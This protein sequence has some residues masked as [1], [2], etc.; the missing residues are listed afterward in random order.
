MPL[1]NVIVSN[2]IEIANSHINKVREDDVSEWH[3]T[4]CL[5]AQ[6]ESDWSILNI[7]KCIETIQSDCQNLNLARLHNTLM[8]VSMALDKF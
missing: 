4:V 6:E 3:S 5:L 2:V 8:P 1:R 7:I